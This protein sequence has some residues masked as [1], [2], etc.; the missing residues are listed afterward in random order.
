MSRSADVAVLELDAR[1]LAARREG[2]LALLAEAVADNHSLGF[3]EPL[4]P[5]WAEPWLDGCVADITAGRRHAWI[6]ERAGRVIG[7]GQLE[8]ATKQNAAHRGEVQKLVVAR[9]AQGTGVGRA[10]MAAIEAR[11]RALGRFLLVLDTDDGSPA[12]GFYQRLGWRSVG[13]VPAY[14]RRP[15]GRLWGTHLFYRDLR[16]TGDG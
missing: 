13:V 4:D 7:M 5:S 1:G 12:V 11:A 16:E 15:D 14:A 10:L 6:A 3:L 2:V 8:L 9:E